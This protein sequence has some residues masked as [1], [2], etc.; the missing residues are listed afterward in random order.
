VNRPVMCESL[1]QS[2][3]IAVSWSQEQTTC[4]KR[5]IGQEEWN[6]E[7]NHPKVCSCI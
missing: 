5:E 1:R 2:Y 4:G 7:C 3:E 6:R